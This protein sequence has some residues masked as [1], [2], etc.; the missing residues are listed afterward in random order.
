MLKQGTSGKRYF[1][2]RVHTSHIGLSCQRA[3]RV[4]RVA[5]HQIAIRAWTVLLAAVLVPGSVRT[6]HASER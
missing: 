5:L 3:E 2:A 1:T 4:Q 6:L